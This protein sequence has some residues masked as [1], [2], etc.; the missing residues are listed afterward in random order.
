MWKGKDE[1]TQAYKSY[2]YYAFSNDETSHPCC[3]NLVDY[4]IFA[5][6]LMMNANFSIGRVF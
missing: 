1:L 6:T 5:H 2:A 4:V 3:K